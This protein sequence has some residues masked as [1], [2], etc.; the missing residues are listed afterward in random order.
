M[1]AKGRLLCE[2]SLCWSQLEYV[3]TTH[4]MPGTTVSQWCLCDRTHCWSPASHWLGSLGS[5]THGPVQNA[6]QSDEETN[7]PRDIFIKTQKQSS[8]RAAP[9][10][11]RAWRTWPAQSP[12]FLSTTLGGSAQSLVPLHESISNQLNSG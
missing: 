3:L 8:P 9:P 7:F 2:C 10:R 6:E 1:A 11:C 5:R 4:C 12:A